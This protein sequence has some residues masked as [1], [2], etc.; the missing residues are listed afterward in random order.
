M[1]VPGAGVWVSGWWASQQAGSL[2]HSALCVGILWQSSVLLMPF[3][4]HHRAGDS[5][6]EVGRPP[7]ASVQILPVASAHIVWLANPHRQGPEWTLSGFW[8]PQV[9]RE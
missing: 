7:G 3:L 8:T 4:M 6:S 1:A 5:V 9:G 2:L